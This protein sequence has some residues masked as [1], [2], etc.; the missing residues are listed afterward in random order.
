MPYLA[1]YTTLEIEVLD[2]QGDPPDFKGTPYSLVI[3]ED[4]PLVNIEHL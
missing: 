3:S 2:M 4:V 1:N